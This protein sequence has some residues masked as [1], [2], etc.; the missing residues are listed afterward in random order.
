MYTKLKYGFISVHFNNKK[1]N[2][3]LSVLKPVNAYCLRGYHWDVELSLRFS[4]EGK[5]Q[6]LTNLSFSTPVPYPSDEKKGTKATAFSSKSSHHYFIAP[7]YE[8]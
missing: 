8:F 7:S 5:G 3:Y 6:I 1:L 4:R 2:H